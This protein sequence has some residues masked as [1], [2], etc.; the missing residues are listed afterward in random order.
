MKKFLI[1]LLLLGG[2]VFTTAAPV[3]ATEAEKELCQGAGLTWEGSA[4]KGRCVNNQGGP[5]VQATIQNV[6]DVLT[7]LIGAIAVIMIVIGGLRYVLSGGDSSA[8]KSA[9]DTIIYAS[10][11]LV[12]TVMAYAIVRFVIQ[13]FA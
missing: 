13:S 1:G 7:F 12:V 10:V 8:T 9:K 4:A 2:M 3:H 5:S 11:G 6:V